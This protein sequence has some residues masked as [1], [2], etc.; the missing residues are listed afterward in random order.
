VPPAS[1]PNECRSIDFTQDALESGSAFRTLIVVD[2]VTRTRLA[3]EVDTS[4]SAARVVRVLDRLAAAHGRPR[5]IT[6]G[7]W[8][9]FTAR[10]TDAWTHAH[11]VAQRFGR[12]GTPTDNPFIESCNDKFR[13]VYLNRH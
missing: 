9:E 12:L 1:R 2:V 10:A 7:N 5:A 3:I 4:L 13:N 8:A 11:G 6:V